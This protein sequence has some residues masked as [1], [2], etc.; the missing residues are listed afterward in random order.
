MSVGLMAGPGE[1]G[2][3]LGR[4]VSGW[5]RF[6]QRESREVTFSRAGH[7]GKAAIF[8]MFCCHFA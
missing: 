4:K 1:G 6:G 8:A 3:G 7:D 2:G 5:A